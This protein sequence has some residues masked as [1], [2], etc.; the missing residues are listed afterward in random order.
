MTEPALSLSGSQAYSLLTSWLPHS[1]IHSLPH[2]N[3]GEMSSLF[4]VPNFFH[5][6]ELG[7]E[8]AL[9]PEIEGPI[10]LEGQ[11]HVMQ[12]ASRAHRL[13]KQFKSNTA[14]RKHRVRDTGLEGGWLAR[15]HRL[16]IYPRTYHTRSQ[17]EDGVVQKKYP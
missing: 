6:W 3:L 12:R 2:R 16:H 7:W 8:A 13:D 10:F 4:S 17:S 1:S 5:L 11:P 9:P 14:K 15:F